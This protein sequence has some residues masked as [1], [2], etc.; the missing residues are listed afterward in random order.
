MIKVSATNLEAYRKYL[1]ERISLDALMDTI[2]RRSEPNNAMIKGTLFHEMMQTNEPEKYLEYFSQDCIDNARQFMNYRS[3]LFEVK[4]RKQ[5]TTTKGIVSM[6]GMADQIL[7]NKV[8][9]IK[10]RYSPINY[11]DYA[12]SLQWR[13]YCDVFDVPEVQYNVFEF[14]HVSDNDYKSCAFFNFF[15][16][17]NNHEHVS[18]WINHYVD[19]LYLMGLE[20]AKQVQL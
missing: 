10:T 1:D 3:P 17:K 19:F 15:A 4:T 9:E 7:G 2:L 20:N 14:K 18:N 6:T 13:V 11:N 12:D 8:I 16:P 5:Y